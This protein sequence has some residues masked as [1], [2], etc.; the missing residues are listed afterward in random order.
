[1][2]VIRLLLALSVVLAHSKAVL[3]NKLVGG[4]IA[5]QAFYII[6]GF[7]MSLILNEKYI[8]KKNSYRLFIS[9]RFLR[10]Y[11]LYWVILIITLLIS[12]LAFKYSS[13]NSGRLQSYVD[14]YNTLNFSSLLYLIISNIILFGQDVVMFLGLNTSD[15]SL[16]FTSD[17]NTT[18]PPLWQFLIITQAWTI[19]L[20]LMFYLVA[21]FIVR[22]SMS[23]IIILITMSIALRVVFYSN[24]Y[25]HDPW[26]HRFFI[27][28]L[29]FFLAGAVSYRLYKIFET[30][31]FSKTF[32]LT[33]LLSMLAFTVLFQYIPLELVYKQW[34]YYVLF[35]IALP[36]VFIYTKRNKLDQQIGE[37]SYPVY[38]SH[39]LVFMV[40][41]YSY[42]Y[43]R[44]NEEYIGILTIIG[45][46][47]FSMLLVKFIVKPI[48]L[49][50]QRRVAQ[51]V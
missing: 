5:V 9:N 11:P 27:T 18:H 13:V 7:Y 1:M 33:L 43:T 31:A 29:A 17:F 48:E 12:L 10:L 51:K 40:I 35:V 24:G 39:V 6:S 32:H 49:I 28:E 25:N 36:F 47:L 41:G 2:G 22:K 8:E 19:G 26:T 45:S 15:G 21:P 50:R 34:I 3:G 23:V 4:M 44:I 42:K 30:S 46:V 14:Y 16:F 37:L 38:L 20:E